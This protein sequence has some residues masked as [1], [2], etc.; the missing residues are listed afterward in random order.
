[1]AATAAVVA[2]VVVVV[3][4]EAVGS[5]RHIA[6]AAAARVDCAASTRLAL[7]SGRRDRCKAQ[8]GCLCPSSKPRLWGTWILTCS[9]GNNHSNWAGSVLMKE[10]T[11]TKTKQDMMVTNDDG[12]QSEIKNEGKQ[13]HEST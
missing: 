6:A 8:G 1:M 4:P 7:V 10:E 11:K 5:V 12:T 3:I 13:L 9:K 2:V